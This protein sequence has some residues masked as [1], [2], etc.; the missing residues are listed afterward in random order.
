MNRDRDAF[1]RFQS[2]DR[3][4]FGD[5]ETS[6]IRGNDSVR[7]DLVDLNLNFKMEKPLAIAVTDPAKAQAKWIWLSKSAI[8]FERIGASTVLVTLP[9]RLAKEKGLV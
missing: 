7:S 6:S 8:E 2:P 1:D 9:G 5:N 4:R 3:G